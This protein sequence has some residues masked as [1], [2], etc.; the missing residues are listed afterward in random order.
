[1]YNWLLNYFPPNYEE[2][3]EQNSHREKILNKDTSLETIFLICVII[4]MVQLHLSNQE[5]CNWAK[6]T[7]CFLSLKSAFSFIL[8]IVSFQYFKP[9]SF[10]GEIVDGCAVAFFLLDPQTDI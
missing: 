8:K 7:N 1:M 3:P 10:Y 2:T 9:L 6:C 4:R 5:Y